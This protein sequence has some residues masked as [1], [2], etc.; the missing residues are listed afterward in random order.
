MKSYPIRTVGSALLGAF[1]LSALSSCGSLSESHARAL[2]TFVSSSTR[3]F[4]SGGSNSRMTADLIGRGV[5]L[6]TGY[7]LEE[8]IVKDR[9][10]YDDPRAYVRDNNRQ[11]DSR[12][13]EVREQNRQ[14]KSSI[15]QAK[16]ENKPLD[17][18]SVAKQRAT[19]QQNIAMVD[20]DIATAKAAS[21]E[22]TH[23][24]KKELAAKIKT[25]SAEK[26]Q[27]QAQRDDLNSLA[28][29]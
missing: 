2:T 25:L 17:K 8:T 21:K 11:L 29:I 4:L 26:K 15:A 5:G 1:A 9:S 6:L 18:K 20:Q 7:I 23:S 12:I 3:T 13:Q 19:M 22:A 10:E 28:T 14:M 16:K 27:M 24:E